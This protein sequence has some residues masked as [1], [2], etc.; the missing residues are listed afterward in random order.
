VIQRYAWYYFMAYSD[1]KFYR[2]RAVLYP[3]KLCL[4]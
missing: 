2:Y 4:Q 1:N 3:L